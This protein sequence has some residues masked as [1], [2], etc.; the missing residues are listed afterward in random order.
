MKNDKEMDK[1]G[2]TILEDDEKIIHNRSSIFGNDLMNITEFHINALR[3]GKLLYWDNGEYTTMV[4]LL[5]N[6]EKK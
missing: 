5:K 1:Y 3:L 4:R 2:I 6:K